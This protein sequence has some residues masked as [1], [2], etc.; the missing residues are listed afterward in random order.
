MP[1]IK[2]GYY[3]KA[4]KIQES[5][6]AH[7]PPHYREI[8]DWFLMKANH[9]NCNIYGKTIKRGQ[10]HCTI[11]DVREGLHWRVG[12]RKERYSQ[13]ACE[14]AMKWF[15]KAE[16]ITKT[17]TGW[18]IIVTICNYDFY[19][20]PKNYDYRADI[21]EIEAE[22]DTHFKPADTR[23]ASQ[24]T[25][26]IS[27]CRTENDQNTHFKPAD[28]RGASQ[29]TPAISSCRTE[30]RSGN[31]TGKPHKPL[32][33]KGLSGMENPTIT[34]PKAEAVTES[35][36]NEIQECKE[37]KKEE[38]KV[39]FVRFWQ[40]YPNRKGKEPALKK[41]L[42]LKITEE[43]FDKIIQAVKNQ[44]KWRANA[45]R[46]EFRPEWPNPTTWLNQKRWED[47]L[48]NESEGERDYSDIPEH[49]QR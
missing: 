15:A 11:G 20:N 32:Q 8:W 22:K 42:K 39:L 26:A 4:R 1:K 13:A 6:I 37:L 9:Q 27:S 47:E 46:G 17:K 43:L 23:G 25:P 3:L 35:V 36:P 48:E 28:T 45:L 30:S 24:Q 12:Y 31:R 44:I 14:N 29:Q 5:E 16:M 21:H 19:Q 7:L 34:E 49:L 40:I 33:E 41:W 10:L 18:G 2:G 38:L